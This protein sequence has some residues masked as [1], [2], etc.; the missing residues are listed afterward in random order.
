MSAMYQWH[1]SLSDDVDYSNCA[2]IH[3]KGDGLWT[4]VAKPVKVV[5][6]ELIINRYESSL[7]VY[8]DTSSWNLRENDLIYTDKG[9]LEGLKA[10]LTGLGFKTDGLEYSEQGRQAPNYVDFDADKSFVKSWLNKGYSGFHLFTNNGRSL[11]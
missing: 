10:I 8:F 5:G 11:K 3:T 7:H 1:N 6:V 9:F 4:K 2:V